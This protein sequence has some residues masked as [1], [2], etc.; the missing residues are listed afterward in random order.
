MDNKNLKD[1]I[2]MFCI[3][4]GIE[5]YEDY[6]LKVVE[7]IS[8]YV[9]NDDEEYY[10]YRKE[11]IDNAFG[12][13]YEDSK[14]RLLILVKEQDF[15]NTIFSLIHEYV[16]FCDYKKYSTYCKNT[17]FRELQEDY[18]FLFWT[19]FHATYLSNSF[20]LDFN[21]NEIDI[22]NVTNQ[23]VNKLRGYY[24]SSQ[25]LDKKKAVDE[26]IRS[27]GCYLALHDRFPDEVKTYPNQY[28]YNRTFLEIYDFLNKHKTYDEFI[29]V[30]NDFDCL[31]NAI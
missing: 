6:M 26:T 3:K 29:E 5:L 4:F 20:L 27:Y 22:K 19:E 24:S 14:G 31:L 7:N 9:K 2:S 13:F 12:L 25:K 28:Y 10:C 23:I 11:Q 15:V 30:Y 8:E 17:Y 1:M 18:V 16:H 21:L